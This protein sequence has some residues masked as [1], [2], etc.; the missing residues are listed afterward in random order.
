MKK[1]TE[2]FSKEDFNELLDQTIAKLEEQRRN[3]ESKV[4]S[5]KSI[6]TKVKSTSI[7]IGED[8]NI[9]I[10]QVEN[11]EVENESITEVIFEAESVTETITELLELEIIGHYGKTLIILTNALTDEPII[12]YGSAA[13]AARA[14]GLNPTTVRTRC[15]K[16]FIDR[17]NRRWKY[18]ESGQSRFSEVGADETKD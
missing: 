16:E 13:A 10:E 17:Q 5:K 3:S 8:E 1:N 4:L 12:R 15:A 18:G 7:E 6:D 2:S 9:E 11:E 14:E